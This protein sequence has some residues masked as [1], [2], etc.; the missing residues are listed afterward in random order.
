MGMLYEHEDDD[1]PRYAS[2]DEAVSAVVGRSCGEDPESLLW[3]CQDVPGNH[4]GGPDCFCGPEVAR[5]E[6]DSAVKALQ[7]RR[8]RVS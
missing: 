1:L 4:T 8:R 6:D 2:L 7:E 5:I 3:V